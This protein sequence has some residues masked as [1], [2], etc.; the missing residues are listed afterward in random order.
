MKIED[1]ILE[2]FKVNSMSEFV[3]S[4]VVPAILCFYIGYSAQVI[5][6]LAQKIEVEVV[7][8]KRKP[9]SIDIKELPKQVMDSSL[10][11][12]D[13]AVIDEI[14]ELLA[15]YPEDA[16]L[17][18]NLASQYSRIKYYKSAERH[19]RKALKL[20]PK[21]PQATFNFAVMYEKRRHW[22][23]AL[24]MYEKFLAENSK[25]EQAKAVKKRVRTLNSLIAGSYQRRTW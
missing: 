10:A 6:G 17:H 4:Y 12:K 16:D 3:Y 25:S 13:K 23:K 2:N 19:F 15:D 5:P 21:H 8:E 1:W 7:E 18:N 14:K 24:K 9:A 22:E 11:R 20:E